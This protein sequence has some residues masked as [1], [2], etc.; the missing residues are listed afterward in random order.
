MP[1]CKWG[2][3]VTNFERKE[4]FVVE[5]NL[6]EG[7]KSV[8][9][10]AL[11]ATLPG[12]FSP[13]EGAHMLQEAIEPKIDPASLQAETLWYE[14]LARL[15][16]IAE[17]LAE[18]R[19]QIKV[20][21]GWEFRGY[22]NSFGSTMT[23][24]FP[25]SKLKISVRVQESSLVK[26]AGAREGLEFF[27]DVPHPWVEDFLRDVKQ[28]K[29][30]TKGKSFAEELVLDPEA[31]AMF[32]HE[33]IGHPSEADNVL[34]NNSYLSSSSGQPITSPEVT[35]V[36]SPKDYPGLGAYPFD[37]EGVFAHTTP[38]LEKGVVRGSLTDRSTGTGLKTESTG[39]A[40]SFWYDATPKVRMSNLVMLPGGK[41]LERIL[42]ET[43]DGILVKGMK[44]GGCDERTGDFHFRPN[45]AYRI[46]N[47]ELKDAV[48]IPEVAG[49][50]K[51]YLNAITDVSSEWSL[52]VA[53]CGKPTP[54][55]DY[56]WVGYGAPF[57]KFRL[58][59]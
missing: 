58:A 35:V 47:G 43:K 11:T 22:Y 40:R 33:A 49:N 5:G 59:P 28:V 34:E 56:V 17:R 42:S 45:V 1:I 48:V 2:A 26:R 38:L 52:T 16:W 54:H 7:G 15:G 13:P 39:N 10:R 44:E 3:R 4:R 37:D 9:A 53:G 18:E 23:S 19:F 30:A 41:S 24:R 14:V 29:T 55:S 8:H 25:L 57:V 6:D 12:G 20:W 46:V 36:D 31:A 32:L 21:S 27:G 50:A 51:S